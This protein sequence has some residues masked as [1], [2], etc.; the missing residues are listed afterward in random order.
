MPKPEGFPFQE[1]APIVIPSMSLELARAAVLMQAH[2]HEVAT[3]YAH[4]L[5]DKM[6]SDARQ[7]THEAQQSLPSPPD[8][9]ELLALAEEAA[10]LCQRLDKIC[11]AILYGRPH[12]STILHWVAQDIKGNTSTV[13]WWL[14]HNGPRG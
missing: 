14:E 10:K 11:N 13:R 12:N 6:E 2:A 4:A 1:A 7:L 5:V 8:D 9:D 3:A